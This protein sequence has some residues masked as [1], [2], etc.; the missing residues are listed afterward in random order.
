MS[1][2]IQT[3]E[4]PLNG[5]IN[6][7]IS[8][9][10]ALHMYPSPNKGFDFSSYQQSIFLSEID[11]WAAHSLEHMHMAIQLI[12]QYIMEQYRIRLKEKID[13]ALDMEEVE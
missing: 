8:A 5:A 2:P 4:D 10:S 13:R 3:Y 12:N 1:E 7:I 11:S 6:E 9:M